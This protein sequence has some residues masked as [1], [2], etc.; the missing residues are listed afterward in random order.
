[1]STN[2]DQTKIVRLREKLLAWGGASGA[3]Y[4]WRNTEDP[5]A[6]LVSE[7]MLHRTQ[8]RQV[9]PVFE[10]F[11]AKFPSL[12]SLVRADYEEVR[13]ILK[14][15]GLTWRIEGMIDVLRRLWDEYGSVPKNK[16]TLIRE[17]NVGPYIA[18]ATEVF[19]D[20]TPLPL[21]DTNTVRVV[22]RV[23]G[24]DLQ[25]EAR[26]RKEIREAIKVCCDPKHPREFY[27]AMIDLAHK[28][29]RPSEPDC[30]GCP[31]LMTPCEF[32]NNSVGKS[33][34]QASY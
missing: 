6:I 31:L 11:I 14:P 2:L 26:R 32:G 19:S 8:A 7:F 22:G 25:G 34:E 5:Y 21:V 29:C 12:E 17:R 15:L 28:T 24:L 23:F 9:E 33:R 30:M 18:G 16:A 20:K 4:P 3:N 1:M 27:Y 13:S 10:E